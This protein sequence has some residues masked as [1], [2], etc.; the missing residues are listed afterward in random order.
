MFRKVAMDLDFAMDKAKLKDFEKTKDEKLDRLLQWIQ[1]NSHRLYGNSDKNKP[2]ENIFPKIV[3]FR[4]LL[5]EIMCTPFEDREGFIICATKFRGTIYLYAYETPERIQDRRNQT[6]RQKRMCCW[7]YKF[8]QYM[9][10]GKDINEGVDENE[11]YCAVF[12]ANI[13]QGLELLYGAEIDGADPANYDRRKG[14]PNCMDS[15]VELKTSKLIETDRDDRTFRRFKIKKWWAQ[16]YLVGIPT[17]VAGFRDDHG[18]VKQL[19]SFSTHELPNLGSGHWK[20]SVMRNFLREFLRFVIREVQVDDPNVMYKFE[21]EKNGGD[22]YCEFL[23][24]DPE[25]TF[26]PEWYISQIFSDQ[27]NYEQLRDRNNK[28][29][30]SEIG[31]Y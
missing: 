21:R 7:G 22:I 15:F 29:K 13:G 2:L 18:V 19:K 20:A 8:E 16:S 14:P 10:Q 30:K 24:P 6:E 28:I 4:G 11:E 25:W 17:V 1:Y 26:L 27:S 5:T 12:C 31:K 9:T 3:C 23:G